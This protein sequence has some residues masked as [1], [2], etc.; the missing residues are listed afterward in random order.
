MTPDRKR[1]YHCV[2][3]IV[4]AHPAQR[5]AVNQKNVP[6]IKVSG[7]NSKCGRIRGLTATAAHQSAAKCRAMLV[8]PNNGSRWDLAAAVWLTPAVRS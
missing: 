3:C 7:R 8:L 6:Y 5:R 2:V 4:K 1:A